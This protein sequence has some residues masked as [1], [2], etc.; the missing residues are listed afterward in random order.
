[1][2]RYHVNLTFKFVRINDRLA[3]Q[4]F[5]VQLKQDC[6][7]LWL[8]LDILGLLISSDLLEVL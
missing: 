2:N 7:R 5:L 3:S 6:R 4:L 8:D 1:M